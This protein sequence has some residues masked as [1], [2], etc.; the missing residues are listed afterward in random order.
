MLRPDPL[1]PI[2][3]DTLRIAR[4]AFP[5]GNLYLKLRD[6][7]GVLYADQDF[8]ALFPALGQPALPPWRLALVTVV[9]FLENLTDRQAA[10]QVRARLDLKYLLG[11]ELTDP[12]FDFSV[13][14]EFRSRLVA[15]Q[16]EHLL[17]DRML[18]RFRE[19]GLLKRRGRQRTDSTHVLAAIRYLTRIELVAETF[20]A[21]LNALGRFAPE[22]LAPRLDP[23]W[24]EWYDH[25]IESYRFPQGK[26][27]RLAY[28]VQVG[29]D[30]FSLLEALRADPSVAPLLSLPAVQTL[31]LV[32]TQ[33][34]SRKD[35]EVQWK[36]GTAVPPSAER[37]ESPYD[38]E[39]RFSTKRGQD[40][41]GYKL[42]L[43]EAC[44]P[45]LP[46]VITHVHV[47]SSCTQD[48]QVMPTVHSALAAKEMLPR[49]HLVDSGYVSGTLLVESHEQYRVEV[50]GPPRSATGWQQKDPNAFKSSDFIVHWD[51]HCVVCPRG[52]RSSKWR[53]GRSQQGLPLVTA[54]FRRGLC[55]RCPD[56]PRCTKSKSLGRSVM[57]QDQAA[58]EA[59]HAMRAQQETPEWKVLYQQRAGIEG[60]LSVAVRAHGAR[61]ARYRGT[62][63][64]RLQS[65]ATAAG[66]NLGRIYAWWQER[67]RAATRTARFA[68]LSITA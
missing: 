23:R 28:V 26:D 68:R 19:Q 38:I 59:L 42:H 53:V 14:S 34:F 13:L 21:T 64:L 36:P 60:T 63:K 37:P 10:E 30:G 7:L 47:S 31:E 58:Y 2:P 51:E 65:M 67:P 43:T 22:W 8:A 49:Q 46:E 50:I 45:E 9:Q 40:W 1:G 56:K 57:L 3:E 27:A 35:G 6:E 44:E 16:A 32:W 20:R 12:G 61:T 39:A 41:V 4:A 11:L 33:Q 66:I 48:I 25:R 5:K 24:R 52:H 29:Q 17:L 55:N 54:T 18:E 15:G 62:A